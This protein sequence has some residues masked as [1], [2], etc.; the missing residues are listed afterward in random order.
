MAI[1]NDTIE[2]NNSKNLISTDG[3]AYSPTIQ[4]YQLDK[5]REEFEKNA[6]YIPTNSKFVDI[7]G[8]E[9]FNT[10]LVSFNNFLYE[11]NSNENLNL[12][13]NYPSVQD[14]I[15]TGV[16][17]TPVEFEIFM[18][19]NGLNPITTQTTQTSNPK[20]VLSSYDSTIKGSFTKSTMGAFCELAPSIFGAVA[21]FFNKIQN[22]ANKI[23]DIINKI[24]NFSLASLLE[25]LKKKILSVVE[26]TI[27]KVKKIVENFTIDG[28]VDNV[29]KFFH[30]KIISKFNVLKTEANKFFEET[31]VE[32]FKKKIEGLIAYAANIFKELKIEE[33][34]F[35]IYRFCSFITNVENIINAIKS[36]LEEFSNNY[37]EIKKI[38]KTNSSTNTIDV[39]S[40]GGKRFNEGE[41]EAAVTKGLELE[42]ARGN[43]PLPSG[44]EYAD[45]P[46]W[47]N[48][49]GDSRVRFEGG[50]VR[51]RP[52][53]MGEDGWNMPTK[54]DANINAK[55]YL[56]R[57]YKEFSQRTGVNQIIINSAYRDPAYNA[58]VRGSKTSHHLR[59]RAFDVKWAGFPRYKAEFVEIARKVGFREIIATY[60]TFVHIGN[61]PNVL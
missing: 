51:P 44:E 58:K 30:T 37:T 52:A 5:M 60:P 32:G 24:Q 21:D 2:N 40:S 41:V 59:G 27:N 3:F 1:C 36:P 53:G 10:A 16:A 26:N 34:Q 45:L 38:L 9:T 42:T 22:F 43:Q 28:L 61:P 12:P 17:I 55:V 14:R 54:T 7:Y 56:M 48:G 8:Q 39:V 6:V 31:N 25:N 13:V 19:D 49:K 29:N 18:E 57:V 46:Q 50:W 15:N 4:F 35:L 23:T 47:N 11:S 33:I 20:T